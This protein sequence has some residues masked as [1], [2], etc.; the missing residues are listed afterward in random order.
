MS[1]KIFLWDSLSAIEW[2]QAAWRIEGTSVAAEACDGELIRDVILRHVPREGIVVDAGCGTAKWPIFLRQRGHRCVG[3]ELAFEACRMARTIDPGLP[4]ARADTRQMPLRTDSVD[5][6]LSLG[7]VEHDEAGP[8]AALAEIHR[9]LRPGGVLVLAVPFNNLWRRL[10]INRLQT[11]LTVRRRAAGM[12][13]A[14]AEY[15][16]TRREV[17]GFVAAAGLTPIAAY[18]N[19]LLPPKINGVWVD[20]DNLVFNPFTAPPKTPEQMFILPGLAG[21][22]ARAVL[23]HAPWL[24]CGEIVMVARKPR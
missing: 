21:R 19:D 6:V 17:S 14:F 1:Y 9:I 13:L 15:R 16:F 22:V 20:L 4:V 11:R 24:V 8:A 2:S 3:V 18:P 5:A 23:R 7:V 12:H 10:V